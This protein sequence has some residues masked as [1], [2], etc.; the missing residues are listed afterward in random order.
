MATEKS[1]TQQGQNV[2]VGRPVAGPIPT[3]Q[4]MDR[5][6]G[7]VMGRSWGKLALPDW[8]RR[9]ELVPRQPAIEITDEKD[10]VIVKAEIPGLK[11]E[12]LQVSLSNS[13]LTIGGERKQ[14]QEKKGK[15]FFYS[16]RSYGSFSRSIQLPADVLAEQASATFKDGILEVRLPKTE[17]AKRKAVKI[18]VE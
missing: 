5:W 9:R 2:P 1:K 4:E 6:F 11:K 17:E 18:K 14:E 7:D 13:L 8:W 15:N 12:N 16:E 3:D 10:A